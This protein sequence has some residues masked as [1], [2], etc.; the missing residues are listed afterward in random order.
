MKNTVLLILAAFLAAAGC[1]SEPA[2]DPNTA[3]TSQAAGK[4][5]K[6]APDFTLQNYDGTEVSLSDYE[7][8]IVVLEWFNYECPF[9]KYHYSKPMI[10]VNLANKYLNKDVIWLRINSTAHQK[11][12]ENRKFARRHRI[13]GPILDDRSGQVGH[14]YKA[15]TTP[16]MF[17][18]DRKGK[19]AYKGAIDNA[20][21]GETD[22]III[23]Y[24]N[25]ALNEIT[26]GVPVSRPETKPY[27]CSVKYAG[28]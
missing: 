18:I 19:I 5:R 24:V 16:H 8:K 23:N 25:E 17:I 12:D 11:T 13:R 22:G 26:R 27:G 2:E 14:M 7:G 3:E 9:V 28:P 10:M 15:K 20:P 4:Q 1:S 21:M 6:K